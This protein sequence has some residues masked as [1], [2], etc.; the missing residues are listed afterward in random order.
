MAVKLRLTRVGKKKQPQYRV[1]AADSRARS[2]RSLHPDHRH[3]QPADRAVHDQ[4]RQR[5]GREVADGRRAAH[6]AREEAA[7]G[8]GRL[9]GVHLGEVAR[10]RPS[11]R[12]SDHDADTGRP[13]ATCWPPPPPPCSPR[14]ALH[15]RRPRGRARRG[16]PRRHRV[17][18]E[19]R[20]APATSVASS[21]AVVA[22]RRASAPCARCR[23]PRRRRGRRRLRRLTDVPGGPVRERSPPSAPRR[24]CSRSADS[25]VPTA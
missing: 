1:V 24:D 8:L 5:Q 22:R 20:S 11:D 12:P 16:Q 4:R 2:R 15:R 3:L 6:R 23:H 9:G 25:A 17:R 14:G 18:L 10:A 7:R 13:T 21:A 19:V